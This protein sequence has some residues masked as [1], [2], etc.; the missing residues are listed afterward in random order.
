[1]IRLFETFWV[2]VWTRKEVMFLVWATAPETVEMMCGKEVMPDTRLSN[3]SNTEMR[4]Y[5]S[6]KEVPPIIGEQDDQA[7]KV[8]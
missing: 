6:I 5:F 2:D 8:G 1:M 3:Q 4:G 7:K